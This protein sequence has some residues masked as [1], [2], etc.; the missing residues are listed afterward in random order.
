MFAKLK[1]KIG[2]WLGS[3]QKAKWLAPFRTFRN[4]L[5]WRRA[6][7]PLKECRR[8]LVIRPDEIG[9]VVMS[10][11][12]FR[13]L[14]KVAPQAKII[15]LVNPTCRSLMEHCPYIDEVH[16]LPFRPTVEQ[17]AIGK[18]VA[19][20]L[21]LRWKHFPFGFDLVLLPRPDADWYGAEMV[22]HLLAWR[23]RIVMNS[24]GF[25]IW[26]KTPPQSP[27]FADVRYC[28]Q[29]PQS[30]VLSNLEFLESCGAA[31]DSAELQL[32]WG[33]EDGDIAEHWLRENLSPGP[34]LVF[35]PPGSHSAFRKWAPGRSRELIEKIL[36]QTKFSVAVIGGPSEEWV[37]AEFA[38]LNHPK[39]KLAVSELTLPQLGALIDRC[40]YF[41]GGDSG[42]MHIAAA[43]RAKVVGLFGPGSEKR[44]APWSANAKVISLRYHCAP[45]GKQTYEACCQTCIYPENRCLTELSAQAVFE[46][47][48]AHFGEPV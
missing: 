28:I 30:D 9:D 6:P 36:A 44:F 8:I 41:I 25:I 7:K 47:V 20:A 21:K 26:T 27:G 37:H 33:S 5:G 12:F 43:T 46:E 32:W 3:P 11:P 22:A 19:N 45:D 15:A 2:V 39:L 18:V 42:P 34:V 16:S 4:K 35:H 40:G 38:G 48:R 10:S 29:N 14:R 31:P 1:E 24:A 13:N 23:G 17:H